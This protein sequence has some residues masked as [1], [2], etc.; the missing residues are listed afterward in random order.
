M[1]ATVQPVIN[2]DP[3]V[4]VLGVAGTTINNTEGN[5][6]T[7]PVGLPS[8]EPEELVIEITHTSTA[9]TCTINAGDFEGAAATTFTLA[10]GSGTATVY[11]VVPVSS[12]H[13]KANGTILLTFAASTTGTVRCFWVRPS[14]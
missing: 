8:A 10:D 12:K 3:A 4:A 11:R 13:L 7:V 5:L 6:I 2:L 9:K 14:A 1:A